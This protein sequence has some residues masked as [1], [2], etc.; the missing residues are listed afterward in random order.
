MIADDAELHRTRQQI[1]RF[2]DVVRSLRER[3]LEKDPVGFRVMA[4][5]IVEEIDV[6]RA[7]IDEYTGAKAARESSDVPTHQ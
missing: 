7:R 5:A 6:L 4:R 3:V 1:A 2:E